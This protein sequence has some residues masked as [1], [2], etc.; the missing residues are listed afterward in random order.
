M[1]VHVPKRAARS[2]VLTIVHRKQLAQPGHQRARG[3]TRSVRR[4]NR[5]LVPALT[6][7]AQKVFVQKVLVQKVL[8]QKAGVLKAAQ[9][10]VLMRVPHAQT[11]GLIAAVHVL[12][13]QRIGLTAAHSVP[14]LVQVVAQAQAP[15]GVLEQAPV[16]VLEQVLV[17]RAGHGPIEA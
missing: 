17:L 8:V 15:A 13:L 7:P 6:A 1:R 5:V 12:V 10:P 3:L 2:V 4:I 11:P 16:G 14:M 9:G